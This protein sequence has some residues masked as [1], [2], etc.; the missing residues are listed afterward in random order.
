MGRKRDNLGEIHPGLELNLCLFSHH[1]YFHRDRTAA[2]I[3]YQVGIDAYAVGEKHLVEVERETCSHGLTGEFQAVKVCI[4]GVNQP[5]HFA[6]VHDVLVKDILV[7]VVEGSRGLGD[8]NQVVF[9][10]ELIG[11]VFGVA[12]AGS[13]GVDIAVH[14]GS[15]KGVIF[16]K[17]TNH[18]GE[19]RKFQ[20]AVTTHKCNC[21]LIA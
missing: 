7:A 9:I 6:T 16:I 4:E 2:D 1:A 14:A 17:R 20:L 19:V 3:H 8:D 5:Q 13:E 11:G 21:R 10:M 12:G 15:V 18:V